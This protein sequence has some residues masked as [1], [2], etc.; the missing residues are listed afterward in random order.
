MAGAERISNS[1]ATLE[2]LILVS[3]L[4]LKFARSMIPRPSDFK[5]GTLGGLLRLRWCFEIER[6][7]VQA[8]VEF[9]TKGVVNKSLT[10][11]AALPLERRGDELQRVVRLAAGPRA[12]V[13]FMTAGVIDQIDKGW[14]K[15]VRQQLFDA[16]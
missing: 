5:S 13:A 7:R 2:T 1:K 12:G 14:R 11:H 15:F 8:G 4:D 10:L 9:F 3:L 6:E 16:L